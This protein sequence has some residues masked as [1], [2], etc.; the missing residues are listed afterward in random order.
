MSV[1]K[2]SWTTDKGEEKSAW[3]VDYSSQGQRRLKTF[4]KK[5][6]AD[7]FSAKVA[8]EISR[9]IHSSGKTT[10][11][12]AGELWLQSR[13]AAGLERSTLVTY[14]Q[15]LDLHIKPFIGGLRLADLTLPRVRQ[16]EDELRREGRSAAMVKRTLVSLSSILAEAQERGLVAQN[17]MHRRRTKN[18][19][20]EKRQ[21]RKLE[22]GL[23]IPAVAEIR[24][25]IPHLGGKRER[26]LILVAVFAG[27][28]ASELRGLRWED[29][30]LERSELRVRQRADCFSEI[31]SPKSK[32][33][34]RSVPLLPMVVNA[35]REWRLACP[36]SEGWLVFPGRGG[37]PLTH[38]AIIRYHWHPLQMRAGL[39]A[40]GKDGKPEPKYGGLHALRH[41]FA[42]WCI[43]RVKDGGLEL[44]GKV[45]QERLGHSTIGLTMDTYSHLFPRVDDADELAKAEAAFLRVVG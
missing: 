2:R 22:V 10:V 44:P 45:V 20:A 36:A 43:N 24:A 6:D 27:L 15:G 23:D 17:V 33:G 31:G 1:R 13:E 42:S 38:G 37:K 19:H 34:Q 3:V 28:R 30:N 11:A 25:L 18:G 16:F 35:L 4:A 40:V 32:A 8:T 5:R 41:F 26:P 39:T 14:R 29:V 9:G 21:E 12:Q 7:A